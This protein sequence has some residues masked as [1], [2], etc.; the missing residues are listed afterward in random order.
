MLGL[1]TLI[2]FLLA[3]TTISH[4]VSA[5]QTTTRRTYLR[6]IE[7]QELT[8]AERYDEAISRLQRLVDDTQNNRYDNLVANQHLARTFVVADRIPEARNLL[9]SVLLRDG[10]EKYKDVYSD[11]TLLNGQL[12]LNDEEFELAQ[13]ALE[14]WYANTTSAYASQVFTLAY[15]NY[16]VKDLPRAQELIE[17]AISN[18]AEGVNNSWYRVYYLVLFEQNKFDQAE[19]IILDLV[20]DEPGN[21]TY[22]RMLANHYL[23]LERSGEALSVLSISNLQNLL[24][25]EGELKQLASMY[26]YMEVPEKAARLMEGWI[27]DETIEV[28][29]P[30]L[31][32]L[33]NLWLMARH[34]DK[35]MDYLHQIVAL[36]PDGETYELLGSL[37]FENEDW[38]A[39]Y[40][41]FLNALAS[42]E[43]KDPERIQMLAGVCAMRAGLIKEAKEAFVAIL[44]SDGFGSQAKGL[45]D[46]LEK[47][48]SELINATL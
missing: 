31:R 21:E 2:V 28:D 14:K 47:E 46:Q 11:L 17:I 3:I 42:E 6:I 4:D 8:A 40:Q 5:Q 10:I 29:P 26:G 41:A 32:R 39:A 7:I 35:A 36:E 33:A 16:M 34:Q 1:R 37:Y 9:D 25:E 43:L 20:N 24:K 23:Q 48:E 22:W 45:L 38:P 12:L 27:A 15:A 44:N 13:Q 18:S 30:A 19:R